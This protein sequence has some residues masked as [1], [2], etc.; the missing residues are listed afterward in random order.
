MGQ[1]LAP[2]AWLDSQG[3]LRGQEGGLAFST[4]PAAFFRLTPLQTELYKRFLRQ[5]KP[6]EELREGKMSVSSLSSIT[7]LKKLCNRELG[8]CPGV[9]CESEQGRVGSCSGPVTLTKTCPESS[10]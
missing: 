3:V 9:L 2:E 10:S 6:A 8:L 1:S 7:S 4:D 5:A